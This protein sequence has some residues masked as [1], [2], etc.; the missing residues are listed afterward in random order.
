MS[1][2]GVFHADQVFPE[3]TG[4]G[5]R[6]AIVD[7]GINPSHS[8]VQSVAGGVHIS[9]DAN[10]HLKF[11][12]HWHDPLGHGTAVAGVIRA[13]AP[14][15][16]LYAV[17]VFDRTLTTH[18]QILAAAIRWA[19][20]QQIHVVNVSLST[21]NPRWGALLQ[22]A[23]DRS[24]RAGTIVI[25]AADGETAGLFPACFQKV[26]AVAA[27]EGCAWGE[28]AACAGNLV[29]FRAHPAPRP[30]PGRPQGRNLRGHSFAAAHLTGLAVRVLEAQSGTTAASVIAVL[31]APKGER[32]L[33]GEVAGARALGY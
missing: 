7:S 31:S 12:H 32:G 23:C 14:H 13:Y 17:R 10:G 18:A 11:D 24:D 33:S 1:E 27:D 4:A 19:A 9:S 29:Q 22:E 21:A 20:E 6:V 15:A 26:I 28:Y 3:R 2:R 30:L 25:A 8:H 5:V 16:E